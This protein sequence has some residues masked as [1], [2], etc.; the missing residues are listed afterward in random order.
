MKCHGSLA[1]LLLQIKNPAIFGEGAACDAGRRAILQ[2]L[3][4]VDPRE[5]PRP[6]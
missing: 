4:F 5:P 6:L 2:R 1:F 3:T